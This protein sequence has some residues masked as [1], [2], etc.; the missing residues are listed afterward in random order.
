MYQ[1]SEYL[2]AIANKLEKLNQASHG[3]SDPIRAQKTFVDPDSVDPLQWMGRAAMDYLNKKKE[4][5]NSNDRN[6]S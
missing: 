2:R 4:H 3:S 5:E 6:P 1:N